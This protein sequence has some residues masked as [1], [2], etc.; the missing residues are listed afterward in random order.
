MDTAE[1][2]ECSL[3]VEREGERVFLGKEGAVPNTR[4]VTGYARGG[5]MWSTVPIGPV[6]GSPHGNGDVLKDEVLYV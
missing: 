2:L 1:I 5:G 3:L 4:R 6:H